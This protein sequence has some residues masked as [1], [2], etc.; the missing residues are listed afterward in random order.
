MGV[1]KRCL[2][3]GCGQG[4]SEWWVWLQDVFGQDQ[5]SA[6]MSRCPQ[7]VLLCIVV[8]LLQPVV[9]SGYSTGHSDSIT[10]TPATSYLSALANTKTFS[11]RSER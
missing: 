9:Y 6:A 11:M 3:N 7:T 5:T 2:S 1:A 4:M 10:C 8:P